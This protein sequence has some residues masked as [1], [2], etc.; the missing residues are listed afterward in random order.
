MIHLSAAAPSFV[1]KRPEMMFLI[2]RSSQCLAFALSTPLLFDTER[3]S[4][5]L[6][7]STCLFSLKTVRQRADPRMKT[8]SEN[9]YQLALIKM[10]E[11]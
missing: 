3:P 6:A 7:L 1:L 2:L 5:V 8:E 9:F 11:H 4:L 10:T